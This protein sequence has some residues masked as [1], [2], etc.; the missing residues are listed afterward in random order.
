MGYGNGENSY[1]FKNVLTGVKKISAGKDHSLAIC[2]SKVMGWG[3]SKD[4]QLGLL[5]KKIYF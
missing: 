3:N 2:G 5:I 1:S 4:G